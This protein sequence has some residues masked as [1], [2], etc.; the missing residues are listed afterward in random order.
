MHYA[1]HAG[2]SLSNVEKINP[3]SSFLTVPESTAELAWQYDRLREG[4]TPTVPLKEDAI[5]LGNDSAY[6]H[7]S[8]TRTADLPSV[9]LPVC[10]DIYLHVCNLTV[11]RFS[12]AWWSRQQI[13]SKR[14][15]NWQAFSDSWEHTLL[16]THTHASSS[17]KNTGS[18]WGWRVIIIIHADLVLFMPGIWALH[19]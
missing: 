1:G 14:C 17:L 5:Q 11:S 3:L 19:C 10:L 2:S 13:S 4:E 6:L 18:L 16:I 9:C 15:E 8:D 7:A 12:A